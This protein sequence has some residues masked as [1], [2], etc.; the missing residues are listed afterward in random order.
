MNIGNNSFQSYQKVVTVVVT[1]VS[2]VTEKSDAYKMYCVHC[3]IRLKLYGMKIL[4]ESIKTL[5]VD[6]KHSLP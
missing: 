1:V 5:N 2:I 6:M 3:V 4:T